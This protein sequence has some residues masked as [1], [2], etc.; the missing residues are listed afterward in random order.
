MSQPQLFAYLIQ[1]DTWLRK[2]K[3]EIVLNDKSA[4]NPEVLLLDIFC[5]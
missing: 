3:A 2:Y 1:V 4:E 5:A